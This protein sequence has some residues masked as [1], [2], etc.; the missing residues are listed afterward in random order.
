MLAAVVSW[1]VH[2]SCT[3][4]CS[5]RNRPRRT[6]KLFSKRDKLKELPGA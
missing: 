4:V 1:P 5:Q 3:G 6:G 2:S